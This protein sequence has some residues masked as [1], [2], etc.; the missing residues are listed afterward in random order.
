MFSSEKIKINTKATAGVLL[1]FMW[2]LC[3][4]GVSL[5]YDVHASIREF[6]SAQ[7]ERSDKIIQPNQLKIKA[8]VKKGTAWLGNQ[9][10]GAF[11]LL[12]NKTGISEDNKAYKT[13]KNLVLKN[14][15]FNLGLYNGTGE[16][17]AELYSLAAMLPT[18]PE[19]VV[20]FGYKYADNP[21]KYQAMVTNGAL[22]VTGAI[23]NPRPLLS[24]LYQ[25]GKNTY[26]EAA[27]DPLTLG[28]LYG[29]TTVYAGSFLLGGTQIKA[30][31]SA[32]KVNKLNKVERA[33]Q[34]GQLARQATPVLSSSL[35]SS[36]LHRFSQISSSIISSSAGSLKLG[37]KNL[38]AQEH[39]A[40]F[41]APAKAPNVRT[42]DL[43]IK[44]KGKDISLGSVENRETVLK[45]IIN[46]EIALTA[47]RFSELTYRDLIDERVKYYAVRLNIG[48][49]D[50]N[51]LQMF[52][53]GAISIDE[54]QLCNQIVDQSILTA[55]KAINVINNEIAQINVLRNVTPQTLLKGYNLER[56]SL[57][58]QDVLE[59]LNILKS[60][61]MVSKGR[62]IES[63]T[64]LGKIRLAQKE[65]K[66]LDPDVASGAITRETYDHLMDSSV[67]D[68]MQDSY[69]FDELK[70]LAGEVEADKEL[71]IKKTAEVQKLYAADQGNKI[72][73]TIMQDLVRANMEHYDLLNTIKTVR[74]GLEKRFT[75]TTITEGL[76]GKKLEETLSARELNRMRA[77]VGKDISALTKRGASEEIIA[78]HKKLDEQLAVSAKRAENMEIEAVLGGWQFLSKHK[79]TPGDVT[80]ATI[81]QTILPRVKWHLPEHY[82]F[83]EL[84]R[85]ADE[86]RWEKEF[87][88]KKAAEIEK[89]S[90]TNTRYKE[91]LL[92][93]KE[94]IDKASKA[95]DDLLK[96]IET[97]KLRVENRLTGTTVTEKLLEKDLK[98]L[99]STELIKMQLEV[100]EDLNYLVKRGASSEIVASNKKL[101]QQLVDSIQE[102]RRKE[103]EAGLSGQ[104]ST[105]G[106]FEGVDAQ[107]LST[108]LWDLT[109]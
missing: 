103:K 17:A 2:I 105:E 1:L 56:L 66:R 68:F 5:G 14:V 78:L 8:T 11:S 46:K 57:L 74:I 67:K 90:A 108:K 40:V 64:L 53:S 82:S 70:R 31:T 107:A 21:E 23:M 38:L 28:N 12:E 13:V 3:F 18:A 81:D 73:G 58:E 106:L 97:I 39:A 37:L 42:I 83:A 61:K 9:Y 77:E 33:T 69:S 71:L 100:G 48:D 96:R 41:L 35:L 34:A 63:H 25:Y 10:R 89:L 24:G 59:Q 76:L 6:V 95:H 84:Q 22:A 50:D 98:T 99:T 109:E 60:S 47:E 29:E 80:R 62:I 91:L 88:L 85:L 49:Q 43:M 45:G 20:N 52:K 51:I 94:A 15:G 32:N 16:L 44:Y 36:S 27:Q 7:V 87:F 19:R 4:P 102:T 101:F 79:I 104:I 72:L 75:G 65:L 54:A 55:D 93:Q 26:T 92:F 30:L 86:V